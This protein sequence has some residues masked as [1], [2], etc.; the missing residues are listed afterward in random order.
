MNAH[1]SACSRDMWHPLL[2]AARRPLRLRLG[3]GLEITADSIV[4]VVIIVWLL[5][6]PELSERAE[7]ADLLATHIVGAVRCQGF[8]DCCPW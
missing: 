3:H 8:Y 5:F 1:H 6:R 7:P 2:L 4:H